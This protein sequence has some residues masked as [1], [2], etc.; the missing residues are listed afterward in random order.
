[1]PLPLQVVTWTATQSIQLGG[2]GACQ[3]SIMCARWPLPW[4]LTL[5]CMSVMR[6]AVLHPWTKFEARKP[7]RSEDTVDFP[8]QHLSVWWPWPLTFVVTVVRTAKSSGI[9]G[10]RRPVDQS[11]LSY[12]LTCNTGQIQPST[13]SFIVITVHGY[14]THYSR[15]PC[16]SGGRKP[17][18]G[19]SAARRHISSDSRC[20]PESTQNLPV[21]SFVHTLTDAYTLFSG[22]A[23]FT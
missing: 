11:D 9:L 13:T 21:L 22:L 19:Q 10:L 15:R 20:F 7:S 3:C 17:S 4:P 18:L 14:E 16:I 23:V 12:R 1:M 6:V 8:S 2:H 5:P